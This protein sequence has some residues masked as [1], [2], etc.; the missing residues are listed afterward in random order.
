MRINGWQRLWLVASILWAVVI[1][2]L[3]GILQSDGDWTVPSANKALFVVR[4]P[5]PGRAPALHR[6]HAEDGLATGFDEGAPRVAAAGFGVLLDLS[7]LGCPAQIVEPRP[8]CLLALEGRRHEVNQGHIATYNE[9]LLE[10]AKADYTVLLSADDLL[11]PGALAR[12]AGG[13]RASRSA[14]ARVP[15]RGNRD[16][17]TRCVSGAPPT[18]C[19]DSRA[20]APDRAHAGAA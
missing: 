1:L 12:A 7:E 16:R 5:A 4:S 20:G 10:W 8:V 15:R 6:A 18:R 3:A 14:V 17:R 11:A 2:L 9:G 19:S 13:R